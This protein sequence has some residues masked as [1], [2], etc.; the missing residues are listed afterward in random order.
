MP[1]CIIL[2]VLAGYALS[3]YKSRMLGGFR[4]GCWFADVSDY[5]YADAAFMIYKK[6]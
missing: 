5:A 2:A 1:V 4:L 3:R 6:K